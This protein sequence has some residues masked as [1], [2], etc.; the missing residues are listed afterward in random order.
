MGTNV[1]SKVKLFNISTLA[2][3]AALSRQVSESTRFFGKIG[4]HIW[5]ISESSAGLETVDTAVDITY[6]LGADINLYD[7]T[8]RQLRVQWNH[9][10]YDGVFVN[11]NDVI[12]VSLMF[13][14]GN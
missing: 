7:T 12:S 2:L 8:S 5:D 1:D 9:Y 3:T 4:A 6:G 13:M 14:L 10:E 11:S